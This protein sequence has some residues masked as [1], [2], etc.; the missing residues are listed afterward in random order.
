MHIL[1]ASRTRI[2][3]VAYGGTERVIWDLGRALVDSG[4]QVTYLVEAG[5]Q[6]DFASV[7]Y[8]DDS[9]DMRQQVPDGVDIAHFHFRPDFDLDQ[10][11]GRPYLYTE[12]GNS[13]DQP[14]LPLNAVFLSAN[15]A[16]RHGSNQFVY[17][18]LDWRHYGPVDFE[19]SRDYFHFLGKA[20]WRVK[21]VAG[22][23]DVA[24]MAGQ[25]MSVLGGDRLNLKRGF[26]FTASPRIR[27]HGMVGGDKKFDLLNGSV[28]LI[29]PVRWHEPF[30]LAVIESLYFGCAVFAT[31]YGSLPEIVTP[32]CGALSSSAG[33]LAEAV[34]THTVDSHVCH[35][36]AIDFFSAEIMCKN[37]LAKYDR[38]LARDQLNPI[39]PQ[40]QAGSR[41]LPW[42]A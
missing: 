10:E 22:A 42:D 40:L 32:E 9:V 21:N 23:I 26:R 17:N 2:P 18:G 37:Y 41:D 7:I 29:L 1:I 16:Q 24:L 13:A 5:S 4:H 25:R 20:A 12:H 27:F 6:C 33:A 31:P 3:V 8:I 15:H 30:G 28:G 34:K 38:V 11:L 14:E 39:A 19:R 36:R 35:Q